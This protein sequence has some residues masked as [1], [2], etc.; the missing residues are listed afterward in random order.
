MVS[1]SN[2]MTNRWSNAHQG[3]TD[4]AR[5]FIISEGCTYKISGLEEADTAAAVKKLLDDGIFHFGKANSVCDFLIQTD[6]TLT[7]FRGAANKGRYDL[8]TKYPEGMVY[9]CRMSWL[10]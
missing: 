3:V 7:D 10:H 8:S 4:T 6:Y 1:E 9:R 5:A 2:K